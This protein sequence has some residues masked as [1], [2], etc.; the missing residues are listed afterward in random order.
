MSQRPNM[1]PSVCMKCGKPLNNSPTL[2]IPRA[3]PGL[4]L[5]SEC[6]SEIEGMTVDKIKDIFRHKKIK[7]YKGK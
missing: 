7:P 1:Y 6:M 3:I 5:C 2:I 4:F